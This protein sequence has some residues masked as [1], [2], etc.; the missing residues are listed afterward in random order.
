MIEITEVNVQ[1]LLKT[2]SLQYKTAAAFTS[3]FVAKVNIRKCPDDRGCLFMVWFNRLSL[4]WAA[5][6][7]KLF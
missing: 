7:Y 5:S 6:V 4:L 3:N 2:N 1:S